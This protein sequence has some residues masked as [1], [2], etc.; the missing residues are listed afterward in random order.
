MRPR[1]ELLERTLVERIVGEALQLL[2][3]PGVRV[4]PSA[5]ALLRTADVRV[6]DGVAHIPE[7]LARTALSHVPREFRLHARGGRPVVHYGGDEVH[8]DPGS[9]C[10]NILDP[11]TL[12][13]RPAL[14]SDLIR[15]VQVTEM[16]P[17]FAAQATAMTC[18]D[19]P[20]EVGDFYRLFLVLLY[21]D[22]PVVTVAFTAAGLRPMLDLL[23]ADSGSADALRS[24]PRAVF[25]VCPSPPLNWSAFAADNLV[26]LARAGVPAEIVS[27]PMRL[28]MSFHSEIFTGSNISRLEPRSPTVSYSGIERSFPLMFPL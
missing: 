28:Q 17:Q 6:Q 21:S 19:V 1:V 14:S 23:A 15:F 3:E 9:S 24:T 13:H 26:E 8:F 22:K 18:A 2:M 11:E 27:M 5:E 7:T 4:A 10:L 12:A 20:R 16:L 25:D